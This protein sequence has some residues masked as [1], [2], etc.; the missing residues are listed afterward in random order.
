MGKILSNRNGNFTWQL[1]LFY[2]PN[3]HKQS[4]RGNEIQPRH[5]HGD[6]GAFAIF[7]IFT[8]ASTTPALGALKQKHSLF[9][10]SFYSKAFTNLK[11]QA[12]NGCFSLGNSWEEG[13]HKYLA[14]LGRLRAESM[15]FA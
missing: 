15:A 13:R 10:L 12:T 4:T 8:P 2:P 11:Q 1:S 7:T 3:I 14:F 9:S 5:K 6:H